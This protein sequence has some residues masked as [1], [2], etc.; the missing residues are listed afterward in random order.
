MIPRKIESIGVKSLVVLAVLAVALAPACA[1]L[2][3]PDK[4]SGPARSREGVE[5]AVSGQSCTQSQ[6]PDFHGEDLVEEVV[7]VQVRNATPAP[8]TVQRDAL[9]LVSPDGLALKT[10]TWRAGDPLA[11]GAGETRAFELRFMNRGS[12]G[13]SRR[14]TLDPDSS[15]KMNGQTVALDAISFVPSRAL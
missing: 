14:M 2:R 13:C 5:L 9:R 12:L 8:L 15:V 1:P 11:L 7:E 3:L 4:N 10:I 6:E